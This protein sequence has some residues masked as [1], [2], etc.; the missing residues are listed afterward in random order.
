MIDEFVHEARDQHGVR[1]YARRNKATLGRRGMLND[2]IADVHRIEAPALCGHWA[3]L[4]AHD[5]FVAEVRE[6]LAEEFGQG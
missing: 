4:E 3:Q 5:R 1:V 2:H 6:F